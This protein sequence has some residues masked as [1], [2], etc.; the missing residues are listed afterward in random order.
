MSTDPMPDPLLSHL[1]DIASD[2]ASEDLILGGGFGI[3]VKQAYLKANNL[4]TLLPAFPEARATQDLDFFLRLA[5]FIQKE[6]GEAVRHLL[7][8]LDYQ[9]H[10]PK[11]QFGKPVDTATPDIRVKVD[12]LARTPR[13]EENIRVKSPRVGVGTGIDIHGR[14]TPEAFAVEDRPLRVPLSGMR[15]NGTEVSASIL[16]PHP[17]AS[18]NMKVKAAHDWL[19]MEQGARPQKRNAA[20]HVF[21]V[22]TLI[23]MLTETE[24]DEAAELASGY[25][26]LPMAV[27]IRTCATELYGEEEAFGMAELRRQL[28]GE[29]SYTIFWSALNKAIG[30]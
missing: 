29:I 5:L 20:R 2:P 19:Q 6:R 23:A 7:D 25:Q 16:V 11:W 13:A 30:V 14:E 28:K 8:R 22:Y 26:N 10:T 17:Y 3:R 12:L 18:L 4:R 1:L 9:E 24:L 15:S 27:E 21:D